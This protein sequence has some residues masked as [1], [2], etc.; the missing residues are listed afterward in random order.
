MG[1]DLL[2]CLLT[3]IKS[4]AE[5]KLGESNLKQTSL[6]RRNR[7]MLQVQQF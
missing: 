6:M 1:T 2:Q 5:K 7:Y 3:F 4:V